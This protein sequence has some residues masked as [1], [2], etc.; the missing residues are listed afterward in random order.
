MPNWMT[1]LGKFVGNAV[2]TGVDWLSK[3]ATALA[4]IP[5][6]LSEFASTVGREVGGEAISGGRELTE[7]GFRANPL[8]TQKIIIFALIG[9]ALFFA[10]AR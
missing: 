8:G 2:G 3:N 6:Q 5:A 4:K 1:A 9:V 7:A 10:F